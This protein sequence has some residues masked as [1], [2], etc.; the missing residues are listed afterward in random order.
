MAKANTTRSKSSLFTTTN[1]LAL[2]LVVAV[3]VIGFLLYQNQTKSNALYI[4]LDGCHSTPTLTVGSKGA[5]VTALQHMIN[6]QF[7]QCRRLPLLVV[8]GAFGPA[9]KQAVMTYQT[10]AQLGADGIVG[11][12]TWSNLLTGTPGRNVTCYAGK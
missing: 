5:C 8:D 4:S 3:A 1:I 2:A 9:T 10:A 11:P 6:W 7:R 12:K